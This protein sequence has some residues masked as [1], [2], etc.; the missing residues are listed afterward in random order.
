MRRNRLLDIWAN[1]GTGLNCFIS[2]SDTYGAELMAHQGF[3]CLTVDLQHGM[4][5]YPVAM[6]QFQAISTTDVVPL[7]RVRKLDEV[8]I[9]RVLD[10]GA[11]GVICPLVNTAEAARALVRYAKYPPMGERSFGPH[12]QMLY[13]GFDYPAHANETGAVIAMIETAEAVE[14][15]LEIASV[16]GIDALYIG[17]A[18]LSL[19]LG[20]PPGFAPDQPEMRTAIDQVRKAADKAGKIAGIHCGDVVFANRMISKGFRFV[21]VL[22]DAKLMAGA[23]QAV[24][25]GVN[26]NA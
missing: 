20:F 15:A 14:N 4:Q 17:P 13:C 5:D 11:L 12:R 10:L 3:D 22:N 2:L 21:T 16:D 18:D 23:A 9:V 6:Q 1:G 19:N 26:R 8:D 7:A 25:S 24:V